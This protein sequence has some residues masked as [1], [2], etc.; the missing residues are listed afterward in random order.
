MFTL[1][2]VSYFGSKYVLEQNYP[3]FKAD[4]LFLNT[5]LPVVAAVLTV[6]TVIAVYA[7]IAWRDEFRSNQTKDSL[8]STTKEVKKDN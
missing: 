8:A 5:L 1:P 6:W 4:N 7:Y 2:F 3:H